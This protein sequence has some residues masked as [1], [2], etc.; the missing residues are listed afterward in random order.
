M[1]FKQNI[2][3]ISHFLVPFADNDGCF[4]TDII[5]YLMLTREIVDLYEAESFKQACSQSFLNF[6]GLQ[7]CKFCW[8]GEEDEENEKDKNEEEM[9]LDRKMGDLGEEDVDKLDE[10]L[11][12]SDE[13]EQAEEQEKVYLMSII[14]TECWHSLNVDHF[15]LLLSTIFT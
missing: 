7:Y 15:H 6:L 9:E 11:W 13:E 12:G 10:K 8:P 4:V 5:K 1:F 2:F 3:K 14:F